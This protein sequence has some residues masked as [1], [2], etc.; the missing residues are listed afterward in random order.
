MVNEYKSIITPCPIMIPIG[1]PYANVSADN[2][3]CAFFGTHPGENFVSGME[4]IRINFKYHR[5]EIWRDFGVLL[6]FGGGF[7]LL[8]L[9]A[10][11]FIPA[12]CSGPHSYRRCHTCTNTPLGSY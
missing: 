6:G 5:N 8:F 2:Q 11:E 4:F 3:I 7:L 1:P 10:A 12:V 9:L